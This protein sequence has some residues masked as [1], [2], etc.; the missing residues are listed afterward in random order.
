MSWKETH[1][2]LK[3]SEMSQEKLRSEWFNPGHLIWINV[4]FSENLLTLG[5][6]TVGKKLTCLFCVFVFQCF[7]HPQRH[8]ENLWLW[9]IQRAQWQKYKDVIC[10]YGG[11]DGSRSDKKWAC[12]WEGGHL[13]S[14]EIPQ[15]L[16]WVISFRNLVRETC[17]LCQWWNSNICK[18]H[19]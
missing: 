5:E 13:V 10:G 7:G 15:N 11:L 1:T 3:T 4:A 19:L 18:S 6:Q 8:C 9:H 2:S 17:K 16:Q 14:S 12:F